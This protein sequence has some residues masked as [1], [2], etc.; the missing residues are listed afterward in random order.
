[1]FAE[2]GRAA[3]TYR[4]EVGVCLASGD[5]VG[6]PR[7]WQQAIG[8]WLQLCQAY[9]WA[10]AV[11]GASE[12]AAQAFHEAGLSA[13]QLGD[14]AILYPDRFRLS[15]PSMRAVRQAV[16]RAKRA[17]LSVRIRRHRDIPPH[18]MAKV[19]ER[20]DDGVTPRTSAA[21]RWRWAV[22]ATVPTRLPASRGGPRG[23]R[24]RQEHGAG[25]R[26]A[27]TG[28]VGDHRRCRWI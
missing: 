24:R 5:P 25:G 20:A 28:A 2:S 4:V 12:S 6:D 17:G 19:I 10:P 22:S 23:T 27:V 13:L 16:T 11:M 8:A 21:S 3:I 26:D 18:E 7:A 15:G 1:M 9:G 14:E